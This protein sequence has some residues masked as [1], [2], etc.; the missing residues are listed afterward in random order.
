MSI[1]EQVRRYREAQHLTQEQLA[2]KVDVHPNT[3]RRWELSERTPNS[4]K[5]NDLSQ[6]LGVSVVDLMSEDDAPS[7]ASDTEA[8][9]V[10]KVPT[11]SSRSSKWMLVYE[12]DGER[13]EL[14]PT[15][16]GY[17]IINRIAEAMVKRPAM[18]T[19]T[20]VIA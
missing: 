3:I 5:L 16:Q 1:G 10:K 13:I 20:A 7:I 17:S 11:S 2:E 14:P 19:Q 4:A 9:P 6:A 15:E 8:L 12:R 18:V